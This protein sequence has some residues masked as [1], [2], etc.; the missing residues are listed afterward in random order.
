VDTLWKQIIWRQFGAGIDMLE[1]AVVA[2][3]EEVWGDRTGQPEYWYLVYH[4]LFWLDLYLSGSAAGFAPPEPF[5]LDELD[6]SGRMPER[7]Y[8]KEELRAYLRHC[9]RKC[10]A[11]VESL[12]EERAAEPCRFGWGEVGYGELLLYNLRHVQ[13]HAAQL[14]LLLRQRAG[15]A[16][17]WVARAEDDGGAE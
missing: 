4:T 12:T 14:N 11:A 8:A 17:G 9:R 15:S 2:C 7:V 16:P 5:T 10:R 3:P 6:P 13:H 1:N